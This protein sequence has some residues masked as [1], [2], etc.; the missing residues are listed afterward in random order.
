MISAV[1]CE[2]RIDLHGPLVNWYHHLSEQIR[3]QTYT[4][5]TLRATVVSISTMAAQDE[6]KIVSHWLLASREMVFG[7]TSQLIMFL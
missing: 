5:W 7:L 6:R 3:N 4:Q 1:G 2:C